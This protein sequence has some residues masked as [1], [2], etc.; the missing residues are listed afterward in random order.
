MESTADAFNDIADIHEA[1]PKHDWVPL[2]EK[3]SEQKGVLTAFPNILQMHAAAAAKTAELKRSDALSQAEVEQVEQKNDVIGKSVLA[4]IKHFENTKNEELKGL[5]QM[6]LR[7][8]IN[9]QL[10]MQ[11]KLKEALAQFDAVKL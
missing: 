5:F 2:V 9:Y 3:M 7:E 10:R 1:Q 8:Q 6:F 4:E 11:A